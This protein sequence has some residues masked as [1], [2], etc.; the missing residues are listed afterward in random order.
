M[1]RNKEIDNAGRICENSK[2]Y[3]YFVENINSF[4]NSL[5]QKHINSYLIKE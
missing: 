5:V 4:T 1:I 3:I 2:E